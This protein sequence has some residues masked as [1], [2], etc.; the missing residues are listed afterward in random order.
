M[1]YHTWCRALRRCYITCNFPF[2]NFFSYQ[3]CLLPLVFEIRH[4]QGFQ[5]VGCQQ[6]A[7]QFSMQF[8]STIMDISIWLLTCNEGSVSTKWSRTFSNLTRLRP[9]IAQFIDYL[10]LIK[11]WCK[12][13][14]FYFIES[15][16]EIFCSKFA[17]I[18]SSTKN[19]W[20][21][22]WLVSKGDNIVSVD[23]TNIIFSLLII[24]HYNASKYI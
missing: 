21:K 11:K 14:W 12:W 10:N 3:L 22:S 16:S 2:F 15:F 19:D 4:C 8:F 24:S 18:T 9:A 1:A 20:Y 17:G 7:S 6:W 13:W 23:V 5:V